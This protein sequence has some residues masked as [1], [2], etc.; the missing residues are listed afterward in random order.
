MSAAPPRPILA[1]LANAASP[2]QAYFLRR[3]AGELEG[4]EVHALFARAT[5]FQPWTVEAD[6]RVVER[7][8][9]DVE[10]GLADYRK[11]GR[12]LDYMAAR[13]VG[14]VICQGYDQPAF[15]RVL[16]GC[17]RRGIPI[18]LRGD[19]NVADDDQSPRWKRAIKGALLRPLL[20]RL[21]GVMPM[22]EAGLAYFRRYGV[23]ASRAWLV[24]VEPDY[25]AI[26]SVDPA[27]ARAF[28][29]RHALPHDRRR[30]LFCARMAPVKRPDLAVGAFASIALRRP[31]W[32][33]VLAGDGP[34]RAGLEAAVPE[35]LRPRIRWMGFLDV[36]E[37]RLLYASCDVLVLPSDREPWALVVNEAMAAGLA[38]VAS[39]TVGAGKDLVEPGVNGEVFRRGDASDLERALLSATDAESLPRL[40]AA[41]GAVLDGW[42]RRADPIEGVRAALLSAGWG[43]RRA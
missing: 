15:V 40:R 16:V 22:G 41:A 19:S 13:G 5:P 20:R 10:R 33:L 30:L 6:A 23:D 8:F 34:L 2:Y 7:S 26:R 1:V 9:G 27:D 43:P 4:V 28:R 31:E 25:D 36:R 21:T 37:M 18:F 29:E 42:R 39:D 35:A 14:A 11:G 24:P 3:L 17:V 38:I 12:I 32:D